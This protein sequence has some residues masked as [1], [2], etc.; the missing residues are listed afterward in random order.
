MTS[1]AELAR[2]LTELH[3]QFLHEFAG[4]QNHR[5]F[6]KK[7]EKE[8]EDLKKAD[9]EFMSSL[10][11][12]NLHC[13]PH[14]IEREQAACENHRERMTYLQQACQAI[15]NLLPPDA[16]IF[17]DEEKEEEKAPE[18]QVREAQLEDYQEDDIPDRF[19]QISPNDLPD[20]NFY[21]E[22]N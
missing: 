14:W 20:T 17:K 10:D 2:M 22:D 5:Y 21:P 6:I 18:V 16:E 9:P 11:K 3:S 12:I 15:M 13:A 19:L 8:L 7:Y 1:A 4:W